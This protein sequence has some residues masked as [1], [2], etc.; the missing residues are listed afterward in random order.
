MLSRV[1][2]ASFLISGLILSPEAKAEE[3]P[4]FT[5]SEVFYD[6]YYPGTVW[7]NKNQKRTIT[8][9][10]SATLIHDEYVNR[11]FT[12]Q[13]IEWLKNAITTWDVYLNSIEFAYTQAQSADLVIGFVPLTSAPNQPGATGYWSAWW[14]SNKIR[15][16]GTI[17]LKSDSSFLNSRDGF[18]HAV[19][20]EVGN[21]LGLGDIRPNSSFESVLEDPWQ[22]PYGPS[23]LSDYD[24]GLIRQLYGESTCP[25][26]WKNTAQLEAE[27]K[28]KA[29]AD[30]KAKAEADA[31]AKVEAEAT[32]AAEA[33]AAQLVRQ[34][35][36]GAFSTLKNIKNEVA[37]W[38]MQYPSLW[39]I[40]PR[41]MSSLE[42][43]TQYSYVDNP[44]QSDYDDLRDLL[45]GTL[46]SSGLVPDYNSA[47]AEITKLK[48]V[49]AKE[50]KSKA[51]IS[52]VKGKLTK[53]VTAVNPKCPSGYKKK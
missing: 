42:R 27:A 33:K 48:A 12:L 38:R 5:Y 53:K 43:A 45:G 9:S 29:E 19:Q 34:M 28:V 50:A 10:S 2:I 47:I 16:K 44:V 51:T 24:I 21:I 6:D 39:K 3:C 30:A 7:T 46:G 32:A 4:T 20:H 8:W 23:N 11:S 15:Y 13:E 18:T 1:L 36:D 41:L 22:L 49:T 17:K 14:D 25:S 40:N 52:C 26:S 35:Y 31:K 37:L